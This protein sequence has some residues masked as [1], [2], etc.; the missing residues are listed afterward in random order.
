MFNP[1]KTRHAGGCAPRA[2]HS[3]ARHSIPGTKLVVVVIKVARSL[4][5]SLS[6][7][8]PE[9]QVD[10]LRAR[11][12]E[13]RAQKRAVRDQILSFERSAGGSQPRGGPVQESRG[14]PVLDPRGG[15]VAVSVPKEEARPRAAFASLTNRFNFP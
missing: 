5:R 10:A 8:K 14:G 12:T 9:T 1:P 7:L 3:D 4:A 11:R 13:T 2:A 6:N 15:P